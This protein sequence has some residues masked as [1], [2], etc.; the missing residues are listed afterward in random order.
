MDLISITFINNTNLQQKKLSHVQMTQSSKNF[1]TELEFCA[2]PLESRVQTLPVDCPPWSK[3][4]IDCV[5]IVP[6][7]AQGAGVRGNPANA[8]G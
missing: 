4:A 6:L 2:S 3:G 5:A 1:K 7:D 8:I